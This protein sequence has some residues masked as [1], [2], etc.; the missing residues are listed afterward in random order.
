[1]RRMKKEE[2]KVL[3]KLIKMQGFLPFF[4]IEN[5]VKIM[6][7]N[8]NSHSNENNFILMNKKM[9]NSMWPRELPNLLLN[10]NSPK[11]RLC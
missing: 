7:F 8:W 9:Y 4:L 6:C 1:M 10:I 2:L 3:Y 11:S 5:S